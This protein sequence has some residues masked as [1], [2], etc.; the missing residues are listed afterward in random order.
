M[1]LCSLLKASCKGPLAL[2]F[3]TDFN[4]MVAIKEQLVTYIQGTIQLAKSGNKVT[5]PLYFVTVFN[6]RVVSIGISLGIGQVEVIGIAISICRVI[7]IGIV[8]S[9]GTVLHRYSQVLTV[10]HEDIFVLLMCLIATGSRSFNRSPA[11]TLPKPPLPMIGPT[12]QAFSKASRRF[13]ESGVRI[14]S[15]SG[16]VSEVRHPAGNNFAKLFLP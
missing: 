4:A 11:N 8:I 2:Y 9:I 13:G 12:R 5:H 1:E 16:P 7:P 3:V 15:R 14:G 6:S 10:H